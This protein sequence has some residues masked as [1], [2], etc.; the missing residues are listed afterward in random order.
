MGVSAESTRVVA[1][2]SP[3]SNA[4][5]ENLSTDVAPGIPCVEVR[6]DGLLEAPDLPLFRRVFAG[7]TLIA[8]LRSS[9]EGGRFA[10]SAAEA[11]PLLLRALAA[12][13]D[14]VDL[15][16]AWLREGLPGFD[17]ATVI[18]SVHDLSG[19]PR[20]L[21]S[22]LAALR[23]TGA[24]YL[25]VVGSA[26]DSG[27][28]LRIL[29]FQRQAEEPRLTAFA[30]GEAGIAT[31][32]LA[33]YFGAPLAYGALLAG[34]ETAPGQLLARDL[35][36]VYGIGR[37]AGIERLYA[38]FGGLVS[39]SLSPAIHN[40][41]FEEGR[42]PSLYVPFA[43]HS[44]LTEFD[45]LVAAFDGFGLPLRGASVTIPF[46]EEAAT[47]A[48]FRGENVA[49]T[50]VRSG[51]AFIASNT[52]RT[53]I[54][55]FAPL[56]FPGSRALVLGAGGTARSAIDVLLSRRYDVHVWS[57]SPVKAH[58]LAEETGATF[59]ANLDPDEERFVLIVNAT[60]VGMKP[61]DPLP[62]P[63]PYVREGMTII[64]APYGRTETRL[65][66][67][68]RARGANVVDGLTLLV[69]QA[70]GQSELF[71]GRP[72]TSADLARRLPARF[73]S[74]FEVNP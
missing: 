59:L 65:A 41:R 12:G 69:A 33:P 43:L 4:E 11:A 70:A 26:R 49:N 73:E 32:V 18:A 29:D 35:R 71:T 28:A 72:T 13:F 19:I 16:L 53:A 17:P 27:D 68:G 24:R 44:L 42:D 21:P 20:D 62:C 48:V 5:V 1:S 67:L 45:P 8:T 74:H 55:S 57:R 50:L 3:A 39:H 34:R 9:A 14:L 38:L 61:D 40:S 60:P 10:G 25:K 36:D 31:R 23:R 6:L 54:L 51:D 58:E 15:E 30:M 64:D 22:L 56:A 7:R 63:D 37:R 46:K 47:V 52:D 2:F 66:G